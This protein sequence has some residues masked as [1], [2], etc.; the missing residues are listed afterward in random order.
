MGDSNV[1][2]VKKLKLTYIPYSY[3]SCIPSPHYDLHTVEN[4]P[5]NIACILTGKDGAK[6]I[7]KWIK[8]HNLEIK[9]KKKFSLPPVKNKLKAPKMKPPKKGTNNEEKFNIYNT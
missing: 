9:H 5:S 7:R 8:K 3:G 2:D 1:A 6:F 4:E